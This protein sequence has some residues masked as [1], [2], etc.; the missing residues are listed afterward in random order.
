MEELTVAEADSGVTITGQVSKAT[1]G[2][3]RASGARP[4]PLVHEAMGA[5][6]C[7]ACCT[8]TCRANASGDR[9]FFY[10]NGRPV[11][12]PKA[13]KA[14]NE[15]DKSL[16]SP[17]ATTSKPMAVVDFR[18]ARAGRG[19]LGLGRLRASIIK[20]ERCPRRLG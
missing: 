10:V 14:L 6:R 11:D 9:Q 19:W 1:A 16:S 7:Q 12:L 4:A 2:S 18:R 3:G 15:T 5:C 8:N 13:T 17:A 20:L